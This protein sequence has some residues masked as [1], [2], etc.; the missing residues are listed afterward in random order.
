VLLGTDGDGVGDGDGEGVETDTVGTAVTDAVAVTVVVIPIP[1]LVFI[2][3]DTE[4]VTAGVDGGDKLDGLALLTIDDAD[5]NDGLLLSDAVGIE[6]I[7]A[8]AVDD[9]DGDIFGEDGASCPGCNGCGLN[10]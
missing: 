8:A 3:V 10:D 1:P 7:F 4:A 5:D 9:N 2:G 6:G